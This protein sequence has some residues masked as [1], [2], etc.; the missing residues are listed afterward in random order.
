MALLPLTE[1]ADIELQFTSHLSTPKGWKAEL[2]LVVDLC[3]QLKVKLG[4]PV[5]TVHEIKIDVSLSIAGG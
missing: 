4:K 2:A 5:M 1:V 3:E